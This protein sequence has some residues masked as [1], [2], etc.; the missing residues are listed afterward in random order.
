MS[1]RL[2]DLDQMLN[3][4]DTNE[5]EEIIT[6]SKATPVDIKGLDVVDVIDNLLN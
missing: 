6:E 2:N 3:D 4:L 5:I 1:A